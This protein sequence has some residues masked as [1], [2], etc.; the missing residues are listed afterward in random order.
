MN[1]L[2]RKGSENFSALSGRAEIHQNYNGRVGN[3]I[4]NSITVAAPRFGVSPDDPVVAIANLIDRTPQRDLFTQTLG[5]HE[6]TT[7]RPVVFILPGQSCDMHSSFI[8][9]VSCF[10]FGESVSPGDRCQPVFLMWPEERMSLEAILADLSSQFRGPKGARA[11]ELKDHVRKLTAHHFL[12]TYIESN[13]W[14]KDNG[15]L[16][17]AFTNYLTSGQ[18]SPANHYH[19]IVILCMIFPDSFKTWTSILRPWKWIKKK[20]AAKQLT[21]FIASLSNRSDVKVLPP[22]QRINRGH[23]RDW[24]HMVERRFRNRVNV[25]GLADAQY[26]VFAEDDTER[27]YGEVYSVVQDLLSERQLIGFFSEK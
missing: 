13:C 12:F 10:D 16:I 4:N 8:E 24:I 3:V 17:K 9:R 15:S 11:T 23:V 19:L 20:L 5:D 26:L 14:A 21:R 25:H 22:L 6:E 7:R 2:R 1:R 18:L 27:P